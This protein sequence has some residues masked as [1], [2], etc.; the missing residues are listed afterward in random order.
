ME[1]IRGQAQAEGAPIND[2][3][4]EDA[5]REDGTLIEE[6]PMVEEWK[7]PYHNGRMCLRLMNA[8]L[9]E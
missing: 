7:C 2:P 6:K 8:E 3:A 1:A 4:A 5:Q 9:G